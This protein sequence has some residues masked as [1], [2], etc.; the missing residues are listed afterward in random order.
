MRPTVM[1]LVASACLCAGC[2]T[3]L[4]PSP[5]EAHRLAREEKVEVWL[6]RPDGK[7]QK[8]QVKFGPGDYCAT[9]AAVDPLPPD[10]GGVPERR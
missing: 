4:L 8:A 5:T 9:A 3:A 7:L 2:K 10:I 1:L 6:R